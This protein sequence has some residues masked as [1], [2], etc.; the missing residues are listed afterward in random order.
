M[1]GTDICNSYR[2]TR[3]TQIHQHM[4]WSAARSRSTLNLTSLCYDS[5]TKHY[6]VHTV[7]SVASEEIG[8][9]RPSL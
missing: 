4:D 8:R 5:P 3:C 2:R 7:Q 1:D 9:L 6:T